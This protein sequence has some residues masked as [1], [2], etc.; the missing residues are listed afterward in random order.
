MGARPEELDAFL[1]EM[2]EEVAM[3]EPHPMEGWHDM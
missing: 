3:S 1:E 2:G